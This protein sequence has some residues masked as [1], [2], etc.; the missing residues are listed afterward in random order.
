MLSPTVSRVTF[1]FR[2]QACRT[3]INVFCWLRVY[4]CEVRDI[5]AY[6]LIEI[7]YL[8]IVCLVALSVFLCISCPV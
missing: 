2:V 7:A 5:V 3:D 6:P 4:P 8:G 1:L